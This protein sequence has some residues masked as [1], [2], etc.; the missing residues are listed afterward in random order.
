MSELSGGADMVVMKFDSEA[1]PDLQNAVEIMNKM[2]KKLFMSNPSNPRLNFKLLKPSHG[3]EAAYLKEISELLGK[4]YVK[5]EE[6]TNNAA[7]D[8]TL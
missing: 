8:E 4:L 2:P 7:I 1:M 3:G 5:S 6:E